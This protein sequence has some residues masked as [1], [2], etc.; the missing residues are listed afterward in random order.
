[1][2]V[3]T[4]LQRESFFSVDNSMVGATSFGALAVYCYLKSKGMWWKVNNEHVKKTLD[5][6]KDH[7]IAKYFKELIE[8]GWIRRNKIRNNCGQVTGDYEYIINNTA[9]IIEIKEEIKEED[10]D[11]ELEDNTELSKNNNSDEVNDTNDST[12]LPKK[13]SLDNAELPKKGSQAESIDTIDKSYPQSSN[14]NDSTQLPKKG[15]HSNT[16]NNT[17]SNYTNKQTKDVVCGVFED[18]EEKIKNLLKRN[19]FFDVDF[20]DK[21]LS[22]KK[23]YANVEANVNYMNKYTHIRDR[24]SYLT[25]AIEF[26]Y[27]KHKDVVI[28]TTQQRALIDKLIKSKVSRERAE[29]IVTS[30]KSFEY[31][32]ANINRC[33]A[34]FNTKKDI[35]NRD[36]FAEYLILKKNCADY[37]EITSEEAKE[38]AAKD[39]RNKL[40]YAFLELNNTAIKKLIIQVATANN[41]TLAENVF[42]HYNDESF[43]KMCWK[44]FM[45]NSSQFLS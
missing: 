29:L 26:N 10:I 9:E 15:S 40:H 12:E 43:K 36:A 30:S 2:T 7:T 38:R 5:I 8:K 23:S 17:N 35:D 19:D 20:L 24:A 22:L 32:D 31:L 3:Y 39:K 13:G 11:K 21:I 6:K 14:T 16:N 1:M 45:N 27:A 34:I 37:I 33:I 44:Y 42:T 18:E 28:L 25:N 4:K 41:V